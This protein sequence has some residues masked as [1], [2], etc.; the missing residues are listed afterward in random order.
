MATNG[1]K[2]DLIKRLT[3]KRIADS[4][5][6]ET[7]KKERKT[8]GSGHDYLVDRLGPYTI[9]EFESIDEANKVIND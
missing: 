7:N 6:S 8:R 5:D 2:N 1:T 4:S 9:K 3:K